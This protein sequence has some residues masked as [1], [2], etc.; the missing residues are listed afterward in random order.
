MSLRVL[1]EKVRGYVCSCVELCG[2][3]GGVW[4][5]RRMWMFEKLSKRLC[6]RVC[7]E[8]MCVGLSDTITTP[9]L[10]CH[11]NLH[12]LLFSLIHH[13]VSQ[14]E[15][16]FC[17]TLDLSASRLSKAKE[18]GAD[19]LL[20]I[21]NESP[22]EIANK[23]EGLLGCKPEVTIECT[24]VE[25]SIQ[26]GIYVSGIRVAKLVGSFRESVQGSEPS[27]IP[28]IKLLH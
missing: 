3:Y 18:V 20:Q 8:S 23:V 26:A 1:C 11:W 4:E 27:R 6:V 9:E 13:P 22:Q 28:R 15:R 19:F 12:L 21:S 14:F 2:M 5:C 24:G 7:L 17:S 10:P 25:T 16:N